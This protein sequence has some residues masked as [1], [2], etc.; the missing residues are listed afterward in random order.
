MIKLDMKKL[1]FALVLLVAFSSCG[2]DE[3]GPNSHLFPEG[4]NSI[5]STDKE[6]DDELSDKNQAERPS[7][8][9]LAM[10]AVVSWSVEP[11]IYL[12]KIDIEKLEKQP[13]SVKIE[14]LK[15]LVKI[16]AMTESKGV[17][18][19]TEE[20]LTQVKLV[21]VNWNR[22]QEKITFRLSYK[23]ITG[24]L[25]QSL[26]FDLDAYFATQFNVNTSFLESHYLQ[27]IYQHAGSFLENLF[28]Y[29]VE[30]FFPELYSK[31]IDVR[32]NTMTVTV[33]I[34]HKQNNQDLDIQITK[35]LRGFKTQDELLKAIKI[36]ATDEIQEEAMKI[37]AKYDLEKDL[38][39]YLKHKIINK[40][41]MQKMSYNIDNQQLYYSEE[42]SNTYSHPI[43]IIKGQG[44]RLDVYLE[45]PR[46]KLKA[47]ELNGHNLNLRMNLYNVNHIDLT[48][49]SYNIV[50]PNVID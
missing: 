10:N 5:S 27:G 6:D 48:G 38:T 42:R 41:W 34:Y 37:M 36:D 32:H 20:D 3:I 44:S 29:D 47:A 33:K 45:S 49:I 39:E 30:K 35:E 14:K 4:N 7:D 21:N 19:F 26:S 40:K 22:E 17:Y 1:Y 46:W 31:G 50:I 9:E 28:V 11:E 43:E 2:K 15:G 24:R 18:H 12:S 25:V 23:N 13:Q 16:E 8:L